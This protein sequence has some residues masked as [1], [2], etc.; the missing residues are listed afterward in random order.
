MLK[1]NLLIIDIIIQ[2]YLSMTE[3]LYTPNCVFNS[4]D[5]QFSINKNNFIKFSKF[6][7]NNKELLLITDDDTIYL[8][9]Y[10]L[11]DNLYDLKNIFKFKE[12]NH[13]YDFDMYKIN[14]YYLVY[15]IITLLMKAQKQLNIFLFV[16]KTIL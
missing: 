7:P 8:E 13:I 14:S 6:L 4:N 2:L 5:T 9:E 10:N 1:T 12:N 3:E 11:I 16:Q 15:M